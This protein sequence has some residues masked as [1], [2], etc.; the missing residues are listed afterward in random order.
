MSAYAYSV[1]K[2][3]L[4]AYPRILAKKYP[5]SASMLFVQAL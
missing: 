1:S 4:N 3:A 2:A 5:H